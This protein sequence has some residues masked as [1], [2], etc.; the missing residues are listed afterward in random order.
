MN[1]NI[2]CVPNIFLNTFY[3]KMCSKIFDF[4]GEKY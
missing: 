2:K 1:D 3:S 4:E